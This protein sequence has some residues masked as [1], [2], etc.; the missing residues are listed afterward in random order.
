LASISHFADASKRR[1]PA[2]ANPEDVDIAAPGLK[3]QGRN[4][5]RSAIDQI[6]RLLEGDRIVIAWVR[7]HHF[8]FSSLALKHLSHDGRDPRINLL[9]DSFQC[10]G[11][12]CRNDHDAIRVIAMS[13]H[14]SAGSFEDCR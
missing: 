6:T 14:D 12:A 3:L 11:K 13:L 4:L 5:D 2:P 1:K 9:A 8:V 7:V 10:Y